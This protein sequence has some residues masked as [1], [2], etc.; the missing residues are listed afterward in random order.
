[1]FVSFYLAA[2]YGVLAYSMYTIMLVPFTIRLLSFAGGPLMMGR[3]DCQVRHLAAARFVVD[4]E[5]YDGP[6]Q[7]IDSNSVFAVGGVQE[8][9]LQGKR[10]RPGGRRDH[11][12]RLR[13][14]RRLA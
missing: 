14:D 5:I 1:M 10:D 4:M 13:Q 7:I 3:L 11:R 6:A 2:L 8:L 12:G 9:R